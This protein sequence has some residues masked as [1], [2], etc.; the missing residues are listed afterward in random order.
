VPTER[1]DT[2]RQSTEVDTE[3]TTDPDP[4]LRNPER[5]MYFARLPGSGDFHTIVSRWL[6]LGRVCDEDLMWNGH[7]QGGTSPVLNAYAEELE[8]CR[9][10]GV[11]VL[12]RPRYDESDSQGQPSGCT[13]NGAPVF[14]AD[15]KA[16]QF[17]HNDAVAAMLGD[18]RDVIAYIHA[19]YLGRGVNGTRQARSIPTMRRSSTI[20]RI[21]ANHR[22]PTV[23]VRCGGCLARRRATAAGVREG[24][25]RSESHREY[26]PPQRLFHDDK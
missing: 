19:G 9:A 21:A 17:N 5:G 25:G 3:Y 10:S 8:K 1:D 26:R 20:T 15:S 18:Y 16:R 22:S 4:E 11:K 13:I 12:F 7:G 23:C 24:T 14:H 6:Y 2:S